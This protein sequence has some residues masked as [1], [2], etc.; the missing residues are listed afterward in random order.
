MERIIHKTFIIKLFT[1]CLGFISFSFVFATDPPV[2]VDDIAITYEDVQL[3]IDILD[4]D[5]DPQGNIDPTSVQ[6]IGLASHGTLIVNEFS[7]LVIYTAELNYHGTDSFTYEVCDTD[8]FCDQANVNITINPVND[9]IIAIDD[10]ETTQENQPV[11]INV[12]SNDEDTFDPMGNVNPMSLNII[13]PPSSGLV[14]LDPVSSNITYTPQTG[15]YGNDSFTYEVCDDG[16]PL[17][18]T[19][20]TATVNVTVTQESP[21]IVND[22]VNINEDTQT[23]IDIL[24]N[25][26]DP[27][28]NF[29]LSSISI[30]SAPLHGNVV[31]NPGT[32]ILS[33]EPDLAY[34]G[35]DSLVYEV[36]DMDAYCGHGS[37]IIT[38]QAVNDP[39]IVND[40]SDFTLENMAVT[41]NILANDTDPDD[42][43]GN[44]DPGT[45]NII[46]QPA[47][48]I[49]NVDNATG[50][51]TYTPEPGFYGTDSYEY[52]VCD[53]GYPLP[54]ICR[55]A[56]VHLTI[57]HQSPSANN[58]FG[59]GDEENEILVN[60]LIND[61]DPQN[62][63]DPTTAEII[64]TSA[65]GTAVLNEVV[66]IVSYIPNEN[67]NGIDS[68][69]YQ[70]CDPDGYCDQ[71]IVFFNVNPV[72][73]PPNIVDDIDSTTENMPVTTNVLAND[74]DINDPSGNIDPLSVAITLNPINGSVVVDPGTGFITYTPENGFI[75]YDQYTY[76]VCDDGNPLPAQCGAA[77][78]TINIIQ[79]SPTAVNDISSTME[80]TTVE[81]DILANDIDLQD[82]ID[83]ESVI[84][85]V[86]PENGNV[87]YDANTNLVTYIPTANYNGVDSFI[88][89]VCDMMGLCD[90]ASVEITIVA[91]NDAPVVNPDTD[92]TAEDMMV[93]TMILENDDDP[94]DPLGNI[95]PSSVSIVSQPSHGQI[96]IDPVSGSVTYTPN[97]GYFGTDEYTYNVCDNG[98]PLPALCSSAS[99]SLTISNQSPTAVD[100]E[101]LTNEDT[102]AMVDVSSNDTDPQNNID[103]G[104]VTIHTQPSHGIASVNPETGFI[105]YTPNLNYYG[106][107]NL[108]YTICD[109]DGYCDQGSLDIIV[110]SVND[111]PVANDDVVVTG[112]NVAVT[113]N[114]L[115]NDEDLY[116]PL[117]AID[118]TS[119]QVLTEPLHGTTTVDPMFGYILYQPD[120]GYLGSDSYTYTVCDNGIPDP[121]LC[122]EAQV[123]VSIQTINH[124]PLTMA[125]FGGVAQGGTISLNVVD[126]DTD[127]DGNL[128]PSTI[129]V[130]QPPVSGASV[131][132][133]E[134]GWVTINYQQVSSFFGSDTMTYQVCDSLG[135][136]DV[137]T[138][139]I[140]VFENN[141]PVANSDFGTTIQS[142]SIT[143]D[144]LE[145]D[146]DPDNNIDPESLEIVSYPK[147]GADVYID[148]NW[149]LEVDYFS[150]PDFIKQDT[151]VYKICDQLNYCDSSTLIITVTYDSDYPVVVP[152]GFSPNGDGVND[153]F[154]IPGIEDFPG[155]EL[156]VYNRWGSKVYSATG[157][158]N[159][160]D[161]KSNN[162]MAF[163]EPLAA[164]TYFYVLTLGNGTNGITGYVYINH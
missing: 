151:I 153:N 36:C 25:D 95:D 123:Q 77:V 6:I 89:E 120:Q 31:I 12:L 28:N 20:S 1:L 53:D 35:M 106:S 64:V 155:N 156:V 154:V 126:N 26:T 82:N 11:T 157:Y 18:P 30:I 80:D 115:L 45:V 163:G 111:Q 152:N 49:V 138:I 69:I 63:I 160:W 79:E 55:Q 10:S 19:C 67:F 137:N 43:L 99:V 92:S 128:D 93:T 85:V 84:F 125:D 90:Q 37:V 161:G 149:Q 144:V 8:G 46:V 158:N 57:D 41:T 142:G 103:P 108:V 7:G 110:I 22:F 101:L 98:F 135:L 32:G 112:E 91:V 96:T 33:Y 74:N 94:N 38:I 121:V 42:P 71:G 87:S 2:A 70:V 9:T 132:T 116:D 140:N 5:T 130:V 113:T 17:P 65:N 131:A 56:T 24:Q 146:T 159:S 118:P 150:V 127:P 3:P 133:N 73:D 109:I 88:Y 54:S 78:V 134:N 21:T 97:T 13:S 162:N 15:F 136:C 83:P 148:E 86:P 47:N 122:G 44:I 29:D 59:S 61:T 51:V 62:V 81:I 4:N 27:Q 60:I 39:P 129:A 68:L 34:H 58:D 100:D 119:V 14:S 104:S 40:D 52:Q 143:V 114:V 16:N 50:S 164:G 117:G 72:N 147:S 105:S 48:G 102:P 76:Q 75:G 107:D 141:S 145:N 139:Y 23:N 124:E 66:G